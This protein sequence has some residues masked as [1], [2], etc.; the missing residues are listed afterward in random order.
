MTKQSITMLSIDEKTMT[1]ELDRAGYKS[2][3]IIVKTAPTFPDAMQTLRNHSIDVVVIN[4]DYL[5]VKGTEICEYLK[6]NEETAA[7]PVIMT[8]V[9]ASSKGPALKAGADL[10]VEQPFPR[11]YFIERIK[12]LLEQKTRTNERVSVQVEAEVTIGKKTNRVPIADLSSTGLLL[13]T[14]EKLS[15]GTKVSLSFEVP[16]YKKP[17]LAQ[18]EVVRFIEAD[19]KNPDRASGLGIKFV[20]F[21]GDSEKRL[22]KFVSKT[23]DENNRMIYYL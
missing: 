1:T 4:S 14:E 19:A 22:E 6:Q 17:I 23:S 2:M 10:F 8:S 12:T 21:E 20:S 15:P 7:I 16:L 13:S 3:G 9:Q 18:G 5:K 11:N